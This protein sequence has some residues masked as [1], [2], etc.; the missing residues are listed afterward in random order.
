MRLNGMDVMKV[1]VWLLL[2]VLALLLLVVVY[3][4]LQ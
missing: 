2:Q 4:L 3:C 1:R